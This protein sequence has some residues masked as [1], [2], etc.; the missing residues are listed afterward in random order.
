[1]K[2]TILAFFDTY[3][4]RLLHGRVE[5]ELQKA[6][7]NHERRSDRAKR[8]AEV[9]W[10]HAPR[11]AASN[12][13]GNATSIRQALLDECPPPSP[14]KEKPKD[15]SLVKKTLPDDWAPEQFG[16]GTECRRIVDN[17]TSLDFERQ[18]ELFRAHH[19]RDGNRFVNWQAAWK[20]WV[21]NSVRFAE[22]DHGAGRQRSKPKSLVESILEEHAG[23]EQPP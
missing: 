19:E 17:W 15:K 12:A 20:T 14:K 2:P 6:D 8:A 23:E 22:H 9:R 16:T 21:L 1:M 7:E 18:L 10:G 4:E 13:R 5:E 11:N 3:G